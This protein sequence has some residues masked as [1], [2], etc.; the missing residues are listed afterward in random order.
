MRMTERDQRMNLSDT[1]I[2]EAV[3][4]ENCLPRLG[5]AYTGYHSTSNEKLPID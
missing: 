2:G 5:S 4:I 1:Q 3:D